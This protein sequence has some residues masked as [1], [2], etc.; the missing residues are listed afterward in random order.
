MLNRLTAFGALL[1][2]TPG[3]AG[4]LY[5]GGDLGVAAT[6]DVIDTAPTLRCGANCLP[7]EVSL[8]GLRLDAQE[9]AW[10]LFAGWDVRDWL[11]L[12]LAYT[13]LGESEGSLEPGAPLLLHTLPPG[14]VAVID[15]DAFFGN[16]PPAV[17][18][19]SAIDFGSASL[20][21]Q[22]VSVN[23]VFRHALTKSF[24][25]WWSLGLSL[26][27]FE[28]PGYY[29][30]IEIISFQPTVWEMRQI[31]FA[32]PDDET[33]YRWGFGAEYALNERF[34]LELGYRR[35]ELQVVDTETLSLRFLI[36]L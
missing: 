12:E 9:T 26:A 16:S 20:G 34:G 24:S 5:V 29:E 28:T 23:M 17:G 1:V 19:A 15:P 25:A 4:S 14:V 30:T 11:S 21:V 7:S 10:S 3:L 18:I 32:T 22:E 36:R 2:S 31:P 8:D 27:T 33:G 35:H 6:D 13:D